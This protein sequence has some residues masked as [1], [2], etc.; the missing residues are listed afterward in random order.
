MNDDLKTLR[1]ALEGN[2]GIITL[3]RPDKLNAVSW[4]MAE[5]LSGLLYRLRFDDAVRA[6]VLAG[7][8]S[9]SMR[10]CGLKM[11]GRWA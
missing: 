2:V 8:A 3:N 7:T 6:I 1:Y 9:V 4:Q 10:R 11:C 5:E